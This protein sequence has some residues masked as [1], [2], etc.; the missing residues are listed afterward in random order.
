V[1]EKSQPSHRI[2]IFTVVVVVIVVVIVW[3]SR[4]GRHNRND[5]DHD[6]DNR[7]ASAGLTTT[8]G[9]SYFEKSIFKSPAQKAELLSTGVDACGMTVL[10]NK[11]SQRYRQNQSNADP[12]QD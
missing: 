6:N 12:R 11:T 4:A 8:S 7:P 3:M 1:V 2:G 5:Y 10:K 9:I